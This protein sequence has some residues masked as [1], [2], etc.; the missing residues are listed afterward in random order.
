MMLALYSVATS[1]IVGIQSNSASGFKIANCLLKLN[2]EIYSKPSHTN[3]IYSPRVT[4]ID[5]ADYIGNSPY[6]RHSLEQFHKGSSFEKPIYNYNTGE[7]EDYEII[8]HTD[9]LLVYGTH[10]NNAQDLC[11]YT[12]YVSVDSSLELQYLNGESTECSFDPDFIIGINPYDVT[13]LQKNNY[14]NSLLKDYPTEEY[15]NGD[16]MGIKITKFDEILL[17]T[18]LKNQK[19]T[20]IYGIIKV[21]IST[22]IQEIII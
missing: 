8:S 4:C 7:L 20:G 3:T 6:L 1:L 10:I 15:N 17:P 11:N 18:L 21:L 5:T 9:N 14:D 13:I 22:K 19:V 12:V 16:Y 2:N